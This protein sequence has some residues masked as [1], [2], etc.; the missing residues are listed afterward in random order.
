[1]F[2]CMSYKPNSEKPY[3]THARTFALLGCFLVLQS[4]L[5]SRAYTIP[6]RHLFLSHFFGFN[7][8]CFA[9]R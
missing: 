4:I 9:K 2:S 6:R 8:C 5:D 7:I 1:M 3:G